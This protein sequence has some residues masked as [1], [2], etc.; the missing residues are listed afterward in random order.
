MKR[1]SVVCAVLLF[2]SFFAHNGLCGDKEDEGHV[3]AIQERIFHR[4]H[5]L[6]LGIAYIPDDDFFY[7]FPVSLAYTYNFNEH[8]AWEVARASLLNTINKDLK[9]D[10][11][12]EFGA[13]PER[14][15][16]P[17]YAIHSNFMYKFLY[18][19]SVWGDR[20]VFNHETYGLF[21]GGL[22]SYENFIR[23]SSPESEFAPS[24]S[25]GLGQKIFLTRHLCLNIELRDWI[26]FKNG[27]T[28][29]NFQAGFSLG[30]RFDLLPRRTRR[31][32]TAEKVIQSLE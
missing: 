4:Y 9:E 16:E 11:E 14:F 7:V 12:R 30:F 27:E 17:E 13:T 10:L 32:A 23:G 24:L 3:A 6:N 22:I 18:G 8:W 20:T 26:N 2:I 5:E 25:L 29:N 19:K 31:D 28:V 1:V 15:S 21:G